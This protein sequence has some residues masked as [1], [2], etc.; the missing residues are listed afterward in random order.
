VNGP[1]TP[2][3]FP[4]RLLRARAAAQRRQGHPLLTPTAR[5]SPRPNRCS[6]RWRRRVDAPG[7]IRIERRARER[8]VRRTLASSRAARSQLL[9]EMVR[10]RAPATRWRKKCSS[11]SGVI[12]ATTRRAIASTPTVHAGAQP[13]PERSPQGDGRAQARSYEPTSNSPDQLERLIDYERL[14]RLNEA[15]A[16]LPPSFVNL[17]S[18]ATARG[19][20]TPRSPRRRSTGSTVRSRVF[21]AICQLKEWAKEAAL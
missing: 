9:R 21:L 8:G 20:S 13:L 11:I 4:P 6:A 7:R 12:A 15:V 14:Y 1:K 3:T 19:S 5:R 2:P 18:C 17:C 10:Q 16:R